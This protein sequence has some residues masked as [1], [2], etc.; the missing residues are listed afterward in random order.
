MYFCNFPEDFSVTRGRLIRLWIAEGFIVEKV[1]QT[2]EQVA[3]EYLDELVQM[4]LV[5]VNKCNFEGRVMSCRV[6]NLVRG[7]ILSK[8]KK[9]NFFTVITK[10]HTNLDQKHRRLS[11]HSCSTST[12]QGKDF[13]HVRTFS[14]FGLDNHLESMARELFSKFKL[15]KVLDLEDASL[16]HFPKEVVK[17]FL[18]RY[19]SLRNTK[20]KSVPR[21]IKKLQNLMILD[22]RQTFVTTLPEEISEI[23]KLLYL[24]V[25]FQDKDKNHAAVG[26]EV[27][28]GIGHLELLHKLS[29]IKANNKKGSIVEEL[30]KLTELRKLGITELKKEDGKDLCASIAKMEHL[31]S[32]Y[33]KSASIDEYL[34]LNYVDMFPQMINN[35]FLGG[36]LHNIPRWIRSLGGLCKIELKWSKL[37]N[38][39]LEA[40]GALPSLK[41]LYLHDAY[42][43]EVLEFGAEWF[44]ELRILVIDQCSSLKIV[45]I[46]EPA[47]PK[48]QK[49]IIKNCNSLTMV[50]IAINTV[51]RLEEMVPQELICFL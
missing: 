35:L 50:R 3:D 39:P 17:L 18:L 43:G 34:D 48:L 44:V 9:D 49:L 1:G 40:L 22:L 7:F 32:L 8:S 46:Q 5:H 13:S 14:I 28:P 11:L 20:I 21:S 23:H 24:L 33:V 10:P 2:L 51:T 4:S 30:G 29:L 41:E 15:L 19:L 16:E 37:K 12:L 38:S 47:M 25:S 42:S 27:S 36:R 26:A 31:T 6:Y 45:V